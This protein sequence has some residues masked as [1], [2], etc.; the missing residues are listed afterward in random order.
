MIF[1]GGNMLLL[2]LWKDENGSWM[3]GFH[4]VMALGTVAGPLLARP[5]LSEAIMEHNQTLVQTQQ[6]YLLDSSAEISQNI[7]TLTDAPRQSQIWIAYSIAGLVLTIASLTSVIVCISNNNRSVCL[8]V[9]PFNKVIEK[10]NS[11]N[12]TFVYRTVVTTSLSVFIMFTKALEI[13]FPDY[14]TAYVAEFLKLDKS[15]GAILTSVYFAAFSIGRGLGIVIINFISPSVIMFVSCIGLVLFSMPLPFF[16]EYHPSLLW[17][18][19][20]GL[21]LSVATIIPTSIIW[22]DRHITI[23]GPVMAIFMVGSAAGDAVGPLLIGGLFSCCGMGSFSY[24]IFIL[25]GFSLFSYLVLIIGVKY[26][27][28]FT[29]K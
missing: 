2:S 8:T 28:K 6:I 4:L 13:G 24:G 16:V 9:K 15:T 11:K 26:F 27:Q 20:A 10:K 22:L 25:T 29:Y 21:G 17:V 7:S 18:C 12:D 14:L 3:Q 23:N 1:A 19:T 5:F